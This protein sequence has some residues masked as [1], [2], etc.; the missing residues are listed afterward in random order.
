MEVIIL[1]TCW[2]TMQYYLETMGKIQDQYNCS[3]MYIFVFSSSVY[4][5]DFITSV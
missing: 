5:S 4:I 2:N 1:Y 3:T